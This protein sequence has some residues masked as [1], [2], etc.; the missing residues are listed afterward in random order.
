MDRDR[1][2]KPFT[3]AKAAITHFWRIEDEGGAPTVHTYELDA[4]TSS[5]V[6]T[7][8]HRGRL[9]VSLPFPLD[10]DLDALVP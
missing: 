2:L 4:M 5:Y 10:I 1:S 3:Y 9:K 8:I 7:G 6:A